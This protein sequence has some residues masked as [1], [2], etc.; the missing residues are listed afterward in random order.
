MINN[1]TGVKYI[2]YPPSFINSGGWGYLGGTILIT[3]K[4]GKEPIVSTVYIDREQPRGKEMDQFILNERKDSLLWKKLLNQGVKIDYWG[5]KTYKVITKSKFVLAPD[6]EK[7]ISKK[8]SIFK[9]DLESSGAYYTFD[10]KKDYFI[11]VELNF[12]R[13]EVKKYLPEEQ[14]DSLKKNN[15]KIFHGILKTK[16]IPLILD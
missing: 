16:K 3:D 2:F 4:E 5:T 9:K 1:D 12:D 15:I 11:Q 14:L 6:K 7:T 10:K 13:T 8:I